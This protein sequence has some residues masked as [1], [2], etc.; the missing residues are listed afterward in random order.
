M[1]QSV[2][3]PSP[4]AT[5]S[6]PIS[7]LEPQDGVSLD[8][9]RKAKDA[10]KLAAWIRENYTKAKDARIKKQT[11]WYQHLSFIFGRQWIDIR[12]GSPESNG[13][14]FF[15]SQ[16]SPYYKKQRTINRSRAFQRTEHAKFL[17]AIPTIN[18]I[19]GTSESADVRA[20]FAGEQVWNSISEAQNLRDAYTKAV[21]WTASVGTGIVK[22]QW[23]KHAVDSVSEQP[24]CINYGSITPFNLFVPDL[25]EMDIEDQPYVIQAIIKPLEWARARWPKELEKINPSLASA[26]A[27]LDESYLDL[28]QATQN[29]PN[30]VVIYEAW[31][32]PGATPLLPNGG[33][34]IMVE[35]TIVSFHE[36]FPYDH[37][38]YPYTIFSHIPTATF[39]ADSPLVDIIPLQREYN[40]YRTDIAE[41]ARRSGRPQLLAPKGSI[42]PSKITNE[43]GLV[44]EYRPGGPPP[45]WAPPPPLPEY[46][47]QLPDIVLR[48]IEDVGGQHEVSRGSAP[49]GVTAGTAITYLGE[50]DSA[51][52]TP[53]FQNIEDGYA[54][55]AK[56]TL[57]LFV[58]YVD[59]PRKIKTIGEDMSYDVTLLSGADI[60]NGTDVRVER[61]SAVGQSKAASD[62]RLM[63]MWSLGIIQDP[64][65][66]MRLL[67]VGGSKKALDILNVAERKAQRENQKMKTLTPEI[68]KQHED[69]YN[70]IMMQA[71]QAGIDP[72]TID[73]PDIATPGESAGTGT[74]NPAALGAPPSIPPAPPVVPVDDFDIHEI[75]LDAHNKFR[76]GQEYEM[77][78]PEVKAEFDKH[79]K[80]HEWMMMQKQMTDFLRM[81]PT[82]GSEGSGSDPANMDVPISS[83][84]DAAQNP[85]SAQGGAT[86]SGNGQVPEQVGG[87]EMTDG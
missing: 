68:I 80:Q 60:K 14:P 78:P 45:Q 69:G 16:R 18:V 20:S 72:A 52:L 41:A 40:D 53:E 5:P 79:C 82:D 83:P 39:Y 46:V 38:Q 51:Y 22:T 24:G 31:I 13:V 81:L 3:Q 64:N 61:G 48:D 57:Q 56:Q 59:A 62:A 26:N 67:E 86:M 75:H 2:P 30:S 34:V 25:R 1:P 47:V 12:K 74:A 58:Q 50:K 32:K 28:Q 7:K 36:E 43:P 54:K 87:G 9:F 71:M 55:I 49:P 15:Q 33:V 27:V 76:M 23:D 6:S 44:I 4:S 17:Q 35:D 63:D 11:Q 8:Q 29:K 65:I 77:L 21:W 10:E 19:P 42:V 66:M 37:G 70:Q 73:S 85:Q 84:L